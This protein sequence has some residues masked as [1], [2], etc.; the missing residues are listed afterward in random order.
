LLSNQLSPPSLI[1]TQSCKHSTLWKTES[2]R[3]WGSK[4]LLQGDSKKLRPF[5]TLPSLFSLFRAF[6]EHLLKEN[7]SDRIWDCCCCC[8]QCDIT[9]SCF[10]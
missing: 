4:F 6:K 8:C 5:L 2:L 3:Y 9:I 1:P 10:M 7:P